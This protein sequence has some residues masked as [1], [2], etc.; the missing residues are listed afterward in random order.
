MGY[1]ADVMISIPIAIIIYMLVEKLTIISI[2]NEQFNQKIQKNQIIL[3]IIGLALIGLAYSVF[4]ENS[5]LN[6]RSLQYSMYLSGGFLL[7]N[8]MILNW[9]VMDEN[10]KVII[11]VIMFSGSVVF[12]YRTAD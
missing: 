12:S 4:S 2:E 11:L 5:K 3:F 8:S 9:D 1:A 6:N 7:F 10:T